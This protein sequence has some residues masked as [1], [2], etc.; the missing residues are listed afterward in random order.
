MSATTYTC[1]CQAMYIGN[2]CQT[3]SP[4]TTLSCSTQPC[5]NNGLC[6]TN[7]DGSIYCICLR[8]QENFK[9]MSNISIYFKIIIF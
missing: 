6:Q 3:Y 1:G 2:N 5:N 9:N 4:A 8:K 7:T